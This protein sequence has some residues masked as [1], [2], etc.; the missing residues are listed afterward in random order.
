MATALGMSGIIRI[1]KTVRQL[2][3][4]FLDCVNNWLCEAAGSTGLAGA[5]MYVHMRTPGDLEEVIFICKHYLKT[6]F[7][8][9]LLTHAL[10]PTTVPL[11][12]RAGGMKTACYVPVTCF[13]SSC[14]ICKQ[15]LYVC[16]HTLFF[17]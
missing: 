3:A 8:V 16:L 6:M 13:S 14:I 7:V 1:I 10:L 15:D 2:W 4:C 11:M 17:L 9:L 5:P 12:R